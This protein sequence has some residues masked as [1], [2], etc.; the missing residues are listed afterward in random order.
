MQ[1][2]WIGKRYVYV[3]VA[4]VI[5]DHPHHLLNTIDLILILLLASFTILMNLEL[6]PIHKVLTMAANLV[7]R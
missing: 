5:L 3:F 6:R 4:A 7:Q 1:R 2:L